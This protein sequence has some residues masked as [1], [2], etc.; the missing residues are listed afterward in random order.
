MLLTP[1]MTFSPAKP[2]CEFVE[3][4]LGSISEQRTRADQSSLALI[5]ALNPASARA[6]PL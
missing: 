5:L 2:Y 1:M 6:N 3:G 4:A